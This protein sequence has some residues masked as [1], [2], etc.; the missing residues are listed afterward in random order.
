MTARCLICWDMFNF[1][2]KSLNKI[3]W[4]LSGRKIS[5]SPTKLVFSGRSVNK[6]GSPG[7]SAKR[8][9]ISEKYIKV[10]IVHPKVH[11]F[12]SFV[13]VLYLNIASFLYGKQIKSKLGNK[14]YSRMIF[15]CV[16][17]NQLDMRECW[18]MTLKGTHARFGGL[19]AIS[20]PSKFYESMV[21]DPL[22]KSTNFKQIVT[23][24][25]LSEETENKQ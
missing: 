21:E 9:P 1:S 16:H 8:L 25:G 5:R 4:N 2:L 3:Q 23:G 7:R 24:I 17:L 11:F 12:F 15:I 14:L 20:F 22:T 19:F 6:N 13:Y 10:I 18:T